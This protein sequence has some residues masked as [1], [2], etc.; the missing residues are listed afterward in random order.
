M[1]IFIID[2]EKKMHVKMLKENGQLNYSLLRKLQHILNTLQTFWT[3]F[4][5]DEHGSQQNILQLNCIFTFICI[6][7]KKKK[8]K[9]MVSV[10]SALL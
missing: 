9:K 7:R 1:F 3:L 4:C 2:V 6:F 5:L 8:K 10:S